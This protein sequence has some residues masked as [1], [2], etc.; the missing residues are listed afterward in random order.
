[1][2]KHYFT[3][4]SYKQTNKKVQINM[5]LRSITIVLLTHWELE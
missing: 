5:D 3:V 1:M 2:I 4:I